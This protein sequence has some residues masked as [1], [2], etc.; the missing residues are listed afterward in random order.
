MFI[1]FEL[2]GGKRLN[3][4]GT[5]TIRMYISH[6]GNAYHTTKYAVKPSQWDSKRAKIKE[7]IPNAQLWSNELIRL[8][9][10]IE[11]LCLKHPSLAASEI[12]KLIGKKSIENLHS[13][14]TNF[15][16]DCENGKQKRA[17]ATI[18]K[19]REALGSIKK[20]NLKYNRRSD[21]DTINKE[22]YDSYTGYLRTERKLNETSV[23]DH[24]K[25]IKAII[26]M[27]YDLG[28]ST[29]IEFQKKYFKVTKQESDSIYLTEDEILLIE[30]VDLTNF[31]HLQAERD[32]FLLSYYFLLRFGDSLLINKGNV[33]D[34]NGKKFIRN[35]SEKTKIESV[36][37]I[38]PK[39]LSL[40][41][42]YN[43]SLPQISNQKANDKLKEIGDEAGI[44]TMT[45][46]SG[47]TKKKY[48]FITSHTAR[49]SAATNLYLQGLPLKDL[50]HLLGHT[51]TSQT[52]QY[53]KMSKLES[54]R[55]ALDFAFFK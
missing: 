50:S 15:L 45:T 29:N 33:F 34:Q 2:K 13:F 27:A 22:W 16:R 12:T 26:R 1:Q 30:N 3:V 40:L 46:I 10:E 23:G 51:K 37:P 11:G 5:R 39:A 47:V 8:K 4:D 41:K 53:I 31:I 49:R 32:R 6:N 25:L 36:L 9:N 35:I 18:K 24:I 7:D 54:A 17:W 21:F 55:K 48:H 44:K 52:E 14:W 43:Y 28:I 19:Y 20:F 38:A 42:K